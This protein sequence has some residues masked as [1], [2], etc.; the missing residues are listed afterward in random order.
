[1]NFEIISEE[2]VSNAEVKKILA[3]RKELEVEQ[4]RAKD[5]VKDFSKLS[6][7]KAD[8]LKASLTSLGIS[9]L[10]SELIILVINILPKDTEELRAILSMSVIPFGD[11]ELQKIFELVKPYL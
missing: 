6:I 2:W 10:K 5:H 7:E 3:E 9:K 8:K 1:M 4:N 11:D